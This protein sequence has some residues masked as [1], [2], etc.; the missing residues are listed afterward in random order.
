MGYEEVNFPLSPSHSI[1]QAYFDKVRQP[2]DV[3]IVHDPRPWAESHGMNGREYTDYGEFPRGEHV[4]YW[5]DEHDRPVSKKPGSTGDNHLPDGKLS[6][7]DGDIGDDKLIGGDDLSHLAADGSYRD[8]MKQGLWLSWHTNGKMASQGMMIDDQRHGPWIEYH[9]NGN[10]LSFGSYNHGQEEGPW[11]FWY[12]DGQKEME[13]KY[14]DGQ[15]DGVWTTWT[16]SGE[17]S[18]IEFRKGVPVLSQ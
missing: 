17:R 4:R 13:G 16:P 15:M 9:S 12:S 5:Y 1:L 8:G 11:T 14:V 7:G 18:K 10:K 3:M 6:R 2:G